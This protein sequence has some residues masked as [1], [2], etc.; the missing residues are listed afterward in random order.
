MRACARPTQ[1]EAATQ[2][3]AAM[4]EIRTAAEQLAAEQEG[5]AA[6][7]AELDDLVGSLQQVLADYGVAI[8][9]GAVVPGHDGTQRLPAA[10][11]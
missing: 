10:I 4:T 2:V 6:N 3:S 7:A 8:G 1:R 11:D 5:R 9:N